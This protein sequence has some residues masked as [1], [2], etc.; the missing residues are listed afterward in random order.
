VLPGSFECSETGCRDLA[1]CIILHNARARR[2]IC[3][4]PAPGAAVLVVG[5]EPAD[6]ADIV[7]ARWLRRG[8]ETLR[9]G[10]KERWPELR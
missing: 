2:N 5:F 4:C 6:R 1:S 7:R 8:I 9:S 3:I 10:A